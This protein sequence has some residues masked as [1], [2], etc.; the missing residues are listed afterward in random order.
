MKPNFQSILNRDSSRATADIAV[1]AVGN[2]LVY[3]K[4]VL[5]ISLDSKPP[6]NW[7]AARVVA[8]CAEKYPELFIPFVNKIAQLY[9]S[10]KNDGLKRSYA[11]LLA[12]YTSYLD[13]G[14]QADLID[15]CFNYMLSDE[16]IAVK[17]NCMKLLFEMTKILPEIRGE[18][19]AAIDYN[20]QQG[21][22]R[23]NGVIKKIYNNHRDIK[24]P[25]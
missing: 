1:E 14:S 18:L 22:F 25:Y 19:Q 16:K 11:W 4:E 7:R 10:F 23:M 15:V 12:K 24:C 5:N 20:L 13:E 9:S 21:I 3:F 17:Y 8:L 6:V 2:M